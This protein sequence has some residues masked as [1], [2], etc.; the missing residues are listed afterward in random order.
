[1]NPKLKAAALI[2]AGF[3]AGIMPDKSVNACE[4]ASTNMKVTDGPKAGK[5]FDPTLTPE[6]DE[7][8]EV[9][10]P[11]H[12]CTQA[13]VRKSSQLGLTTLGI[14]VVGTWIDTA[15]NTMA[16]VL[17]TAEDVKQFNA[18]TLQELI[19]ES[20]ALRS[21]VKSQTSRST[22]GST[23]TLKRFTGGWLRLLGAH[24]AAGL[25]RKTI[26]YILADEVDEYPLDLEGQGDPME[27]LHARQISFHKSGEYKIMLFS[28][29]TIEGIS[30]IDAAFEKGDQRFYFVPCPHCKHMHTYDFWKLKYEKKWPHNAHYFCAECGGQITYKDQAAMRAKESG[31]RWIATNDNGGYP[32]FHLDA[33]YSGFTTWDHLVA[34]FLK[35][36]GSP[37]KLKTFYNLWLGRA[38]KVQ[39]EA[40]D[41]EKLYNRRSD[42]A[43][44]RIPAGGLFLTL[45]ADVQQ[46]RIEL[47]VVAW[48]IGKTSYSVER[49]VLT[50]DTMQPE[51]WAKLAQVLAGE[52]SDQYGR[53]RKIEMACIDAG[54]RP[55]KVYEFCRG[56]HNAIP[57]KGVGGHLAPLIGTP[58]KQD[59]TPTGGKRRSS[60]MLWPLGTWQ[61]KA[62]LYGLLNM[63]GPSESG[64]YPPGWC[65]FPIG[66]LYDLTF[67]QGLTSE[68]LVDVPRRGYIDKVWTKNPK[69][70]NEPLDC[71]VYAMA[72]AYQKGMGRFTPEDW[73]K[74]VELSGPPVK[75]QLDMLADLTATAPPPRTP[76]RGSG[77]NVGGEGRKV[78]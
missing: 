52:W 30:R 14:A 7:I 48:G 59:I 1:M 23:T 49:G 4:W 72:A 77:R 62:E 13:A 3:A 33:M 6:F 2:L 66:D 28:T 78:A 40:P 31:A 67:F 76:A 41:A 8:A 69:F 56:R 71:R 51:V 75:A 39:S 42:Y 53:K 45:G 11:G 26:K 60:V 37:E 47:E 19:Q 16:M 32:S 43:P 27:M 17:P 57:I 34:T 36:E 70:R 9:M 29:P 68:Q 55:Q 46:A 65:Y 64:G 61:L 5:N 63:E 21:K 22:K 20:P 54:Y 25:R 18:E 74:L 50:G 44:G 12:P 73:Q 10:K 15:P 24:S 58:S 38:F 35:A